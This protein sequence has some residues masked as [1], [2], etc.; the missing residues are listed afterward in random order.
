MTRGLAAVLAV[1]LPAA[2]TRQGPAP[3]QIHYTVGA[4]Y[5]AGGVWRYP[6]ESVRYDATGLAVVQQ[7][8]AQR[9]TADGERYDPAATAGAHPTLPLPSV[10]RVTNL[11]TGR[12]LLLRL[13]DRGPADPGRLIALTPAAAALLGIPRDGVAR[14]RVQLEVAPSEALRDALGAGPKGLAAPVGTVT[15]EA[16]P[17]PGSSLSRGPARVLGTDRTAESVAPPADLSATAIQVPP[18]P[19]ALWLDL[20][21][22]H[23]PGYAQQRRA[24]LA[25]LGPEIER[26][27]S[28]RSALWRVHAGPFATVADADNAM[29]QARRAGVFDATITAQRD[30]GQ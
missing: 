27:G 17:P 12:Q 21:E 11:D 29:D 2:C 28:G 23:E 1:L 26:D 3:G 8:G 30:P 22:F 18:Q 16:L 9:I 10:V 20:G 6:Q 4:P 5:Q 19:G 15:A 7:G 14:V 13:N 25:S 24:R